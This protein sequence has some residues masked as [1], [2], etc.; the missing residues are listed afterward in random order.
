M[1]DAAGQGRSMRNWGPF[2]PLKERSF[3]TIWTSSV[4]SNF[5]QLIL[6]VGAA[7]EMTRLA[8]SPEMVAL[9]QSALMLPMMLVALPAGAA[10]DMFDRRKVA[11]AGLGFA[12]VCAAALTA[13]ALLHLTTPWVLLAFCSLIGGGVALY[14]PAWQASVRE[15]VSAEQ[16]PAAVALGSISYNVAR[17][18]GPALGGLVILLAG[19]KAAFAINAVCYLP[20][21][22]AFLF[23]RRKPAPSRLPPERMDRAIV[24]GVRYA[25]HSP[26][27]RTVLARSLFY[28]FVGS[29]ISALT[30]LVARTSL[31]G[32]AGIYGLLLGFFGAGAV[33]GAMLT[34]RVRDRLKAEHAVNLFAVITGLMTMAIGF[35]HNL[36]V[37]AAA[38][39]LA[40]AAWMLLATMLNLGVQ[41]AAPRWVTARALSLYQS[42]LT[43]G[44]ALGAWIW[45]RQATLHGVG[46]ALAIS[47]AVLV[48]SPLLGLVLPLPAVSDAGTEELEIQQE[49]EVAL[50]ITLKSGPVVIEVDYEIDP[51]QA[52]QFYD[53]MLKLQRARQR[54]GAFEWSL[55]RDIADPALWTERYLCPTWG[56]YLRLR[57]RF[58]HSDAALQDEA[59]AYLK[60]GRTMRVRRRLER[61]FGS[62]RWR[63]ETPDLREPVVA[64][65]P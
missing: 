58:T 56:D 63:T 55:S 38:M 29:A 7:W 34:G 43:G 52:R 20:L 62:V 27:I 17:S 23:W 49:P 30:P 2:E 18:F 53:A 22:V 47:G 6:G 32:G 54:N 37:T 45:G 44:I 24:S 3:A 50:A 41:F 46:E 57:S 60:A 61:P 12:V 33:G 9:V 42:S 8:N 39:A 51:A 11:M 48:I 40:G 13:L 31:H 36:V 35:S 21:F 25:L 59:R 28:G 26:P 15:Q 64:Y 65:T 16:L 4:L 10:A 1:A 5:G 14:G 19:A